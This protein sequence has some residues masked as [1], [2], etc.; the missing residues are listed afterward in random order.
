MRRVL[1]GAINTR[2]DIYDELA[3]TRC[4]RASRRQLRGGQQCRQGHGK[5]KPSTTPDVLATMPARPTITAGNCRPTANR[6]WPRTGNRSTDTNAS[7]YDDGVGVVDAM[8]LPRDLCHYNSYVENSG[9][10]VAANRCNA[11]NGLSHQRSGQPFGHGRWARRDYF[12]KYHSG[13]TWPPQSS[14]IS[15]RSPRD[16]AVYHPLRPLNVG[17]CQAN[18][19]H[20]VAAGSSAYQYG[21]P[22]AR[23][24]R[25]V[26]STAGVLTMAVVKNCAGSGRRDS[27]AMPSR[28]MNGSMSFL[29]E[30]T[31]DRA[32]T[33]W[34]TGRRF[35]WKSFARPLL[36]MAAAQPLPQTIRRDVP[37]LIE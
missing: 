20:G 24:A 32:E 35:I 26:P 5:G 22:T 19:P 8:G 11:L 30:P 16:D 14:G 9:V 15:D 10:P 36:A 6:F 25:P 27:Q 7:V 23:P 21:R 28:S 13:G 31:V 18:T 17:A 3:P 2:F 29:V 37:Y 33:V 12:D 4:N 1:F 34:R